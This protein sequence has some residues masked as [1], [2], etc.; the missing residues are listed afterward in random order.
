[1]KVLKFS[2]VSHY[3]NN[4]YE[5]ISRLIEFV[6]DY[7]RSIFNENP[8]DSK[9]ILLGDTPKKRI[10]GEVFFGEVVPVIFEPH[11][12]TYTMNDHK[13]ENDLLDVVVKDIMLIREIIEELDECINVI[14]YHNV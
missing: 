7:Y 13:D 14:F 5:F 9:S 8:M 6:K 10:E 2:F 11:T 3:Y 12:L 1:M 4:H